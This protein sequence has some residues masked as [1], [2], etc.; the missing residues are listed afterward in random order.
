MLEKTINWKKAI[1]VVIITILIITLLSVLWVEAYW[2]CIDRIKFNASGY[3]ILE[4]EV[5]E[6][7]ALYVVVV[8]L[9]LEAHE[10][11]LSGEMTIKDFKAKGIAYMERCTG[12][13]LAVGTTPQEYWELYLKRN[14]KR[15]MQKVFL[16]VE[17]LSFVL[18]VSFDGRYKS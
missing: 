7:G 17:K 4:E 11:F 14:T 8:K 9:S 6:K 2:Y 3:K 12:G 5:S 13:F 10:K 15:E 1:F 16:Q 18:G